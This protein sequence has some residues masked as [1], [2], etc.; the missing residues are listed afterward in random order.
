MGGSFQDS[1]TEREPAMSHLVEG[2]V[3]ADFPDSV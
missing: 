2:E 3:Q 1:A